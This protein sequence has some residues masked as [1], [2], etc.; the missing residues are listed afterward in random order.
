[1]SYKNQSVINSRGGAITVSSTE[2]REYVSIN[3]YSGASQTLNGTGIAT[4]SPNNSQKKI[5]NDDFEHVGNDKSSYVGGKKFDR[6]NSDYSMIIGDSVAMYTDSY[7]IWNDKFSQLATANLQ[8]DIKKPVVPI[9]PGASLEQTPP[10][11]GDV[12]NKNATNP[13]ITDL[14]NSIKSGKVLN[15]V[16]IPKI[17]LSSKN[18]PSLS[19]IGNI[20]KKV[21]ADKIS[22]TNKLVNSVLTSVKNIPNLAKKL[23]PTSP[24]TQGGNYE[25]NTSKDVLPDL[26][27]ETQKE[28]MPIESNLGDGG[29]MNINVAR[30]ARLVVG[31]TVNNNPQATVDM[32]GR[33][34][35]SAVV[36]SSDGVTTAVEGAPEVT[37]VDNFSM[38]PCGT[39]TL[40]IGN[41]FNVKVGGGGINLI[42]SGSINIATDTVL[43]LGSLQTVIGGDD[44]VIKGSK[45][46]SIDSSNLNLT[47]DSQIILNGNVGVN[48]NLLIKGG[49]YIDGEVCINHITA[50]RE[51][52]QTLIGFTKEGARGFLR[53][54]DKITGNIKISN[55]EQYDTLVTAI[56]PFEITL[57]QQ[58]DLAVE[59]TPHGHEFPNIPLTLSEGNP[60]AGVS[61]Q[62]GVRGA[63]GVMNS[64]TPAAASGINNT[65]KYPKTNTDPMAFLSNDS[66]KNANVTGK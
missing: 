23:Q 13:A 41:L 49:T 19:D 12:G 35:P 66:S 22:D 60:S 37:E 5:D 55:I 39:Y 30:N 2:N 51:I 14:Q 44:V 48:S 42:T 33:Q 9:L 21:I 17:D 3:T 56:F 10:I 59:L 20:A 15:D 45:N 4:F 57:D 28:L 27:T 31:A 50:P 58:Q 52:Q 64:T 1:M 6:V 53:S 63:A 18:I 62:G 24:S 38:F 65:N 54:G 36:V 47:S 25:V 43:K 29:S 40:E 61:A 32:A 46:V 26:I 34:V 16:A 8:P 11:F 7:G